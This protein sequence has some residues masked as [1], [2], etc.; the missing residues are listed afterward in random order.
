MISILDLN[1]AKTIWVRRFFGIQVRL[2]N[3]LIGSLLF[4]QSSFYQRPERW[5][6]TPEAAASI[7]GIWRHTLTFLGGPRL[8]LVIDSLLLSMCQFSL[9]GGSTGR[10]IYYLSAPTFIGLRHCSPSSGILNL[11]WLCRLKIPVRNLLLFSVL[12]FVLTRQVE[13]RY[14]CF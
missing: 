7:P 10:M 6:T 14:L 13:N 12:W 2:P 3:F 11:N 5:E 8:A 4:I 1:R 9:S